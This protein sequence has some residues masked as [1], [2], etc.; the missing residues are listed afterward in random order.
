[1]TVLLFNPRNNNDAYRGARPFPVSGT[2]HPN[3]AAYEFYP[4]PLEATRALLAAERFEGSIWEPAC[5]QGHIA[6]VLTEHHHDVVATDLIDYGFGQRGRDFLV[7]R[8]PLAR[9]I[10][11]NPPY[12][13]GLADAFC[14]HALQL[15]AK[16]G[17]KVAMLV[18]VQSLCHPT[19]TPFFE[20]HPPAI[21]YAV[22]DCTC[23][24]YG[25]PNKA[26][27]SILQQRYCWLVWHAGYDGPTM[28]K[29]L[30]TA[31]YKNARP[32]ARPRTSLLLAA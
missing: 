8:E 4:T 27:R 12:G 5:G 22:D 31:P 25:D 28:F 16:T 19:R 23:Y 17:G 26:T 21:I 1:M 14:L 30:R 3:R 20:K 2:F 10:I 29:W 18:A 24:P 15:T 32:V 11:T 6:K 9:N 7:E 13:R